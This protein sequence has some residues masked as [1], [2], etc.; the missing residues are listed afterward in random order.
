M[1]LGAGDRLLRQSAVGFDIDLVGD[2]GGNWTPILM[3]TAKDG[4][5]DEA[6]ALDTGADDF[7]RKPFS[8][9]RFHTARTTVD[10]DM[11]ERVPKHAPVQ[12]SCLRRTRASPGTSTRK[13]GR[14]KNL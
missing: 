14:R 5:L 2:H 9:T 10:P 13:A 1:V 12:A 8:R 4:D 7:L 11:A 3:L 6:E